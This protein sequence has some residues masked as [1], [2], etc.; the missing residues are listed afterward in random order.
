MNFKSLIQR[1][2]RK[3]AELHGRVHESVRRRDDGPEEREIWESACAEFHARY[4]SLAFPGGT[5]DA[6]ERMRSG[7]AVAIEY[8]V[9]FIEVRPYFFRSGYMYNDFL[10]VL[11]NCKLTEQQRV[12]YDRVRDAYLAYRRNRRGIPD[13]G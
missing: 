4:G 7:D 13:C 10:R 11:K 12:R 5:L 1:N 2:A 9:C 8:A 6:R 3:I